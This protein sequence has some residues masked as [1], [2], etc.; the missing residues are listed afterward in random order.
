MQNV[1][2][3]EQHIRSELVEKEH[4][5]RLMYRQLADEEKRCAQVMQNLDAMQNEKDRIG[6]EVTKRTDEFNILN[7]KL[8]IMQ[9]A[10]DRGTQQQL[11]QIS[12][13]PSLA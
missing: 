2:V 3:A 9:A 7:E 13:I 5:C 1:N 10:L 12:Y 8:Q 11:P 4:E 6:L